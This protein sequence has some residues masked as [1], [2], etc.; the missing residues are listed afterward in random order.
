MNENQIE[1]QSIADLIGRTF[2]IPSYQRGYRWTEKEVTALLDDILEFS[3]KKNKVASEFYC[4]QPIVVSKKEENEWNLIDG[5]QRLTTIFILLSY[6]KDVRE[7]LGGGT[8]LFAL[9]FETRKDCTDFLAEID[10]SRSEK[11]VDYYHIYTS[12]LTIKKWFEQ[13]AKKQ[14]SI[15]GDFLKVLLNTGKENNIRVIWYEINDGS[16]AIDIFT[17]LNIGKI[18]LTNAE[19]IKALFLQSD[20]FEKSEVFLKQMEIA[21]EWDIIEYKLQNEEFWYFLNEKENNLPTRIDFIFQIMANDINE[22][23]NFNIPRDDQFTFFVF[24]EYFANYEHLKPDKEEHP[25]IE[26]WREVKTYFLTFE[27]WFLD[28]ELYHLIGYLI[29]CGRNIKSIMIESLDKTKTEFRNNLRSDIKSTIRINK[30]NPN[31]G[32][33]KFDDLEYGTTSNNGIITKILLL[34]NIQSLLNNTKENTRFPFDR[35]KSK[36][37]GWSLEHIH[38]QNSEG[39]SSLKEWE[40]WIDEHLISL[41]RIEGQ[42][43]S[44]ELKELIEKLEKH[45][46]TNLN[47]DVFQNLFNAVLD[48]FRKLDNTDES[49][50][51]TIQNLALIDK[52][53]NSALNKAVFDVK[54]ERIKKLEAQGV[55][56]PL[57]TKNVFMKYYTEN[58]TQLY[59]WSE[60]DRNAYISSIKSILKDYLHD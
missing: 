37:S 5:Q 39:L 7:I 6:L 50:M 31:G 8:D 17:R 3:N 13:K 34:F 43:N 42:G 44:A 27:E 4:L 24:N 12:F 30:K 52:D 18:P 47:N 9:N 33:M 11:N 28:R 23:Y 20:N 35:Y 29:T 45:K 56:I 2:F 19:L 46:N 53:S 59:F 36:K 1:V 15:K 41:R 32:Y 49:K 14:V 26:I 10:E 40:A 51:H 58:P 21:S 16:D 48:F 22:E 54:R 25:I 38:A 55:Y 60:T 57:C